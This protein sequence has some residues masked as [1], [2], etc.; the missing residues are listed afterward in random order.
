MP[1]R[2]TVQARYHLY[3]KSH[4]IVFVIKLPRNDLTDFYDSFCVYLVGRRIGRRQ[5][6]LY[7]KTTFT[8]STSNIIIIT[9]FLLTVPLLSLSAADAFSSTPR[10]SLITEN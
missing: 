2:G 3:I 10:G 8:W 6:F 4:V 5:F 1:R 7:S 9:S